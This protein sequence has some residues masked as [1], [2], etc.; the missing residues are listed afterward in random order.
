MLGRVSASRPPA[1]RS[2]LPFRLGPPKS[3]LPRPR[4]RLAR[5]ALVACMPLMNRFY[6]TPWTQRKGRPSARITDQVKKKQLLAGHDRIDECFAL[7]ADNSHG[8]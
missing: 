4:S 7:E 3:T 5:H 6:T 8:I 2:K 1:P